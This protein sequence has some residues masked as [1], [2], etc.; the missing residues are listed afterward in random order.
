MR[1][2][3]KREKMLNDFKHWKPEELL[4]ALCTELLTGSQQT[5]AACKLLLTNEFTPL[6]EEQKKLVV[7]IDAWARGYAGSSTFKRGYEHH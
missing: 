4:H 2:R 6:S 5:Q 3:G 1:D 7:L